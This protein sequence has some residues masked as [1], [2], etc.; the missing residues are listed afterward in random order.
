[1]RA[2]FHLKS[3]E[4]SGRPDFQALH[5]Q[6]RNLS[7]EER[8]HYKRIGEAATTARKAGGRAFPKTQGSALRD[9]QQQL[10]DNS[11]FADGGLFDLHIAFQ[12]KLQ[13]Q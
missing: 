11:N 4:T 3:Q 9:M 6:Y 1:M 8:L 13:I 2:F 12:G 7:V 5:N 10:A